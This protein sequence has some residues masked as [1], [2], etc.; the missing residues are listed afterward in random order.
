MTVNAGNIPAEHWTQDPEIGGGR[1][2]GEGCHFI[3]LLRFLAGS[4]ISDLSV[5]QLRDS[6]ESVADTVSIALEFE[7]GS[8]GVI[9]YLANGHRSFPKERLEVFCA[10]RVLQLDNFR[11]LK[12]WG[13]KGFSGMRLRRQDKGQEAC[14]AA[15]LDAVREGQPS[16][17]PL[18]EILEVSRLSI[19]AQEAL[20]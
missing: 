12:A 7:N 18:D 2:V 19:E 9:H 1:I 20:S 11:Q 13:W 5:S 3:D 8:H 17:I 10:G 14:A 6:A 16:P 15:F 4:P